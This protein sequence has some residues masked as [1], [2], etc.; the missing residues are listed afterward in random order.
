[1]NARKYRACVY[2]L[3][4]I[5]TKS[6]QMIKNGYFTNMCSEGKIILSSKNKKF[7]SCE[8]K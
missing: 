7:H 2:K 8:G 1:M 6:Y 3:C 5:I 4:F